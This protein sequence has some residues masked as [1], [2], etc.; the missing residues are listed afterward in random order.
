VI[1]PFINVREKDLRNFA[2]ENNL[3]V[4]AENCPACFSIPK[5]RKRTKALLAAQEHLYPGLFSRLAS[6]IKPLLS[7]ELEK[8]NP[9]KREEHEQR[10]PLDSFS[11]EELMNELKRRNEGLEARK[12]K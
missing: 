5:E 10:S 7:G 6:A 11:T 2:I 9:K 8:R 1:R 3:P 12:E 4:I